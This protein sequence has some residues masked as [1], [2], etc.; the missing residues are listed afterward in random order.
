VSPPVLRAP[1]L[2]RGFRLYVAA[3]EHM[4]GA[5]LTQEDNGKEYSGGVS[6]Q[7]VGRRR[8]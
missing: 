8:G 3:H 1:K 5:V 6:Q 2:D 7:E 4:I